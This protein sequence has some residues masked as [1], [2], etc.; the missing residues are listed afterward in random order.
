MI[1]LVVHIKCP[2]LKEKERGRLEKGEGDSKKERE[3]E[4]ERE[5]AAVCCLFITNR[6]KASHLICL[7]LA[8]LCVIFINIRLGGEPLWQMED[9]GENCFGPGLL[10]WEEMTACINSKLKLN[11]AAQFTKV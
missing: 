4:R 9:A 10:L 2:E 6:G 7:V 5:K 8:I 3:R 1:R 11:T